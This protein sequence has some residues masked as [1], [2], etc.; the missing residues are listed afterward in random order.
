MS[1]GAALQGKLGAALQAAASHLTLAQAYRVVVAVWAAGTQ[2]KQGWAGNEL[3]MHAAPASTAEAPRLPT[4]CLQSAGKRYTQTK[5]L[6]IAV[7]AVSHP[8]SPAC[9]ACTQSPCS[10]PH[11]CGFSGIAMS[12]QQTKWCD[13]AVAQVAK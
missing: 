13:P 6:I 8:Q 10:W 9:A 1:A 7:H 5:Q 12:T 3:E 4:S 2:G 11:L